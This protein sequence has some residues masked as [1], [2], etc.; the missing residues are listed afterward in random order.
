MG[1]EPF[2]PG[3]Q[4]GDRR[5]PVGPVGV[6]DVGATGVGHL[7]DVAD[8]GE[9]LVGQG[10]ADVGSA[11]QPQRPH[12]PVVAGELLEEALGQRRRLAPLPEPDGAVD[13]P[14]Q[15]G[16]LLGAGAGPL[17]LRHRLLLLSSTPASV[18]VPP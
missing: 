12:G 15:V 10:G 9:G 13:H 2:D 5:P 17:R 4:V 3:S 11:A 18:P 1:H 14:G 7:L 8:E 16:Q 6:D